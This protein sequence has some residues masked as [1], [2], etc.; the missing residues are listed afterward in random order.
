MAGHLKMLTFASLASSW[1]FGSTAK[2]RFTPNSR[3]RTCLPARRS[4]YSRPRSKLDAA[5]PAAHLLLS[6]PMKCTRPVGVRTGTKG[7]PGAQPTGAQPT[8]G[9]FL[10]IGGGHDVLLRCADKSAS[11]GARTGPFA[12]TL[13]QLHKKRGEILLHLLDSKPLMPAAPNK[14][15]RAPTKLGRKPLLPDERSLRLRAN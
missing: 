9:L 1:P 11:V 4:A 13:W 2:R 6:Q 12:V 7:I 5:R 15:L 10:L 8:H 3:Y 14:A